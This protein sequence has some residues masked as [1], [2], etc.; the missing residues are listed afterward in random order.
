M[1]E[2]VNGCHVI[3]RQLSNFRQIISNRNLYVDNYPGEISCVINYPMIYTDA[4]AKMR[5]FGY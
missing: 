3:S 1:V 2:N 5:A 4:K